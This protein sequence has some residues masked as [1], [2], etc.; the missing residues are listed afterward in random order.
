M[1]LKDF[2]ILARGNQMPFFN[3]D[4]PKAIYTNSKLH[5]IF[6]QNRS[7][8]NKMRYTKQRNFCVSLLRKTKRRYYENLNEK[9]VVENKLFW[10]NVKPFLSDKVSGKD[11]SISK[12]RHSNKTFEGKR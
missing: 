6:L 10:K 7:E 5:N 12:F 3:K 2:V 1:A 8:E 11:E 4:L 9:S